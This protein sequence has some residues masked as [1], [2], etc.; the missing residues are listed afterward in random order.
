MFIKILLVVM[1]KRMLDWR[2]NQ[3]F[4][5]SRAIPRVVFEVGKMHAQPQ[6]PLAGQLEIGGPLLMIIGCTLE[7]VCDT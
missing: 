4:F 7:G 2:R 1:Q 6:M 5:Q 3:R